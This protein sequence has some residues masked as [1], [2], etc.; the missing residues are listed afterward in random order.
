MAVCRN[1]PIDGGVPIVPVLIP[2][3]QHQRHRQRAHDLKTLFDTARPADLPAA[4]GCD[5]D[6]AGIELVVSGDREKTN[7]AAGIG[8]CRCR[9]FRPEAKQPAPMEHGRSPPGVPRRLTDHESQS[10]GERLAEEYSRDWIFQV[11]VPYLMEA[12]VALLSEKWFFTGS[13]VLC[14]IEQDRMLCLMD[15]P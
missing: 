11:N 13:T 7:L 14:Q 4:G 12:P 6:Q 9:G 15:W 10:T 1:E 2:I 8:Q 3:E 5:V